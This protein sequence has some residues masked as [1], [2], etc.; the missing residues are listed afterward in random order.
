[1]GEELE[2]NAFFMQRDLELLERLL[3]YGPFQDV[4]FTLRMIFRE[5][6]CPGWYVKEVGPVT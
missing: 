1:M 4:R 5:G 6:S 2:G 3:P